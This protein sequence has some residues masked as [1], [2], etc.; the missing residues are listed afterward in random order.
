MGV[1]D[2]LFG[3]RVAMP[4]PMPAILEP[5][6]PVNYDSVLDWMLGLSDKDYKKMLEVV[7]IYRTAN[8]DA[9]KVLKV[10]DEPTTQLVSNNPTE[11][12]IDDSLDDLL[13]MDDE[14]L[15]ATITAEEPEAP[16][17]LQSPSNHKKVS[18]NGK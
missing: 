14:T 6:N 13:E 4:E 2:K 1:R 18:V 16:K 12:E 15:K 17:K 11:Q 9:A 7:N 3:K 10:K 8:K 5:Q